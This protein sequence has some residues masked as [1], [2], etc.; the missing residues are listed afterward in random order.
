MNERR[1]KILKIIIKEHINSGTPVSSGALVMK[2][3]LDISPAT[4]RSE[5]VWLEQNGY[6]AQPH[7]SAGRIPTEK[8]YRLFVDNLKNTKVSSASIKKIEKVFLDNSDESLKETAKTVSVIT[9]EAIFWAFHKRNLF[10][11]GISN[12][13]KQPEFSQLDI[14]QN[15]SMVIDQMEEIIDNNFEKIEKGISV[16]IGRDNPFGMF[17]STVFVK[18]K[19]GSK[20]GICGI[21]G[22]VRMNYEKN[23]AIAEYIEERIYKLSIK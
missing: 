1:L 6:I 18:Y 5:M 22:P 9:E 20:T 23:L 21:L 19:L 13:F 17:C 8:A 3:K 2:Y 7:T 15:L 10:Y 11:T 4:T 16:R 12:L 14:I